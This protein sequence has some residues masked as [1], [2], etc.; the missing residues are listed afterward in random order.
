M[1]SGTQGPARQLGRVIGGYRLEA[2]LGEGGTGVVYRGGRVDGAGGI[3]E[4]TAAAAVELPPVAAIKLLVIPWNLNEAA[5][6]EQRK[7]FLREIEILRALKHPHILPIITD[8]ADDE[9]DSLYMIL[10][11]LPGGSLGK[12]LS[13]RAARMPLDEVE[14]LLEQIAS[15]MDYAYI[16]DPNR[17]IVHRDIKPDNI[18]LSDAGQAYLADFSIAQLIDESRTQLTHT[19]ANPGTFAYMSP[20]AR[21]GEANTGLASD[22]YSLG[23]VVYEMVAGKRDTVS[24]DL[25]SPRTLNPALPVPAAEVILRALRRDPAERFATATAFAQAFS[26]GLQG[27]WPADMEPPRVADG[28]APPTTTEADTRTAPDSRPLSP[29]ARSARPRRMGALLGGAVA[30][31]L[32]AGVVGMSV[33]GHG[34]FFAAAQPGSGSSGGGEAHAHAATASRTTAPGSSSTT[35]AHATATAKKSSAAAGP[36]NAPG[37]APGSTP[38]SAPSAT[39]TSTDPPLLP[40]QIFGDGHDGS[41]DIVSGQIFYTDDVRTSVSGSAS[42]GQKSIS[43]VSTSG[44]GAGQ[45]ALII[46]TRGSGAGTY[47]FA[48]VQ[49]VSGG[50]LTFMTALQNAYGIGAQV[51]W[52]PDYQNVTVENGGVITAHA[53]DGN[54][55]GIVAF[56]VRGTLIVQSGGVITVDNL[57]FRGGV[58][59]CGQ[60]CW[61]SSGY[62][63]ESYAG[64]S[65]H[66]YSQ[67]GGAGGGGCDYQNQGGSGGS[68]G[69]TGGVGGGNTCADAANEPG[70]MY[71]DVALNTLFLGSGGG[72]AGGCCYN[73]GNGA[74]IIA[75]FAHTLNNYGAI[76]ARGAA[77][78]NGG[79]S[80]AGAGGSG[81][82]IKLISSSVNLGSNQVIA[83]GGAGGSSTGTYSGQLVAGGAGGAGRVSVGY[84]SSISGYSTPSAFQRLVSCSGS[85]P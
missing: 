82:S 53:W 36:T 66:S 47:E 77:G 29:P 6:A 30:L 35:S 7:R 40:G 67:N 45:E 33:L 10:P 4:R 61:T 52:T 83:G 15:A 24:G 2:V 80:S 26:R 75:I 84:C 39:S 37:T 78:Q 34:V 38:A 63:G 79:T 62:T 5:A 74:G 16:H 1:G 48:T 49:S 73:G 11:Y 69:T 41:L 81:G 17:R 51:I 64:T 42:S 32:I 14:R 68:Y 9:T 54:T 18:L 72:S 46:Q 65:V 71:G 57:G 58:M 13:S 3:D 27:D 21:L 43:V 12:R 31:L 85:L 8:G 28:G 22:I 59:L 56:Q 25:P 60:G 44:F 19:G 76:S 50:S 20:E 23:M 55:G 70:A